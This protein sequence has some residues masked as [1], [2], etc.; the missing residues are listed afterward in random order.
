MARK[1]AATLGEIKYIDKVGVE[2]EGAWEMY[3]E[4][5]NKIRNQMPR[6]LKGDSSVECYPENGDFNE[7]E[8][9]TGE[10]ASHPIVP[11]SHILG[12]WIARNYPD[13]TDETCGLH[14]HFS[15]KNDNDYAKL[16]T[17]AFCNFVNAELEKFG[18][19]YK[20]PN[21]HELW[22]RING[23]R[24]YCAKVFKGEEQINN[25]TR[26]RY[27]Q[28]NFRAYHIHGTV[29]I[30]TL[31]GFRDCHV[32][33]AAIYTLIRAVEK[34]ISLTN[35]AIAEGNCAF[36]MDSIYDSE[37]PELSDDLITADVSELG[38]SAYSIITREIQ[39]VEDI[40]FVYQEESVVPRWSRMQ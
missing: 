14:V 31:P 2:L 27:T 25:E 20:L 28:V 16:I 34:F 17:P 38:E 29:E 21:T 35:E 40:D 26:D 7:G 12:Q 8:G 32:A 30:R 5:G 36:K 18:T 15:L 19:A 24:S 39:D 10:I 3:D 6:H 23:A 13:R 37:L 33:I 22:K 9:W 1:R 11:D 4:Y